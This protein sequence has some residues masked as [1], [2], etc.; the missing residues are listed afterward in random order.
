MKKLLVL[1]SIIVLGVS[2]VAYGGSFGNPFS[3]GT[4]PVGTGLL[5]EWGALKLGFES[6]VIFKKDIH[7]DADDGEFKNGDYK[8]QFYYSKVSCAFFDR[9]EPFILLGASNGTQI[10][11]E[12]MEAGKTKSANCRMKFKSDFMWGLGAK[13]LAFESEEH[14]IKLVIQGQYR[15][16]RQGLRSFSVD[17]IDIVSFLAKKNTLKY[18]EWDVAAAIGKEFS[19]GETMA[20]L[21]YVGGKY[22]DCRGK[23]DLEWAGGSVTT[24]K[25]DNKYKGGPF[26][27]C[28]LIITDALSINV[29]GRFVSEYALSFGLVARF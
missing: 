22:S 9:F 2:T 19:L 14:G 6:D 3:P 11:G 18:H 5:G 1:A 15:N 25:M 4:P 27:G 23:L 20:V 10:K 16:T 29:E 12:L 13:V 26:I 24:V 21:P 7:A 8:G 28:D 17:E